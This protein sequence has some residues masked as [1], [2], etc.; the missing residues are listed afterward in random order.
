MAT[1]LFRTNPASRGGRRFAKAVLP[2]SFEPRHFAWP[3]ALPDNRVYA[4]ELRRGA[5]SKVSRE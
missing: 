5:I 3:L 4:A 1:E 2:Y